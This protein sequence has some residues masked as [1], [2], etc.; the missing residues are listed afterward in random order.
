MDSL[1]SETTLAFKDLEGLDFNCQSLAFSPND[2]MLIK[3]ITEATMRMQKDDKNN[4]TVVA[5]RLHMAI[6]RGDA[7][8]LHIFPQIL[9]VDLPCSDAVVR[10]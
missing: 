2:S 7:D 4:A 5:L 1:K 3:K 9:I 10:D 8:P 6:G